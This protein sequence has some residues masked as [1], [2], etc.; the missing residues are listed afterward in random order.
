MQDTFPA[1]CVT[2]GLSL[3]EGASGYKYVETVFLPIS[4]K[5]INPVAKS[6]ATSASFVGSDGALGCVRASAAALGWVGA[7]L[8]GKA[9][10]LRYMMSMSNVVT[11]EMKLR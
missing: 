5:Y 10:H 2:A 1:F 8:P 3:G 9:S 6:L 7:T 4:L 11:V